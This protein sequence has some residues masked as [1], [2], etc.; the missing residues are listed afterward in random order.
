MIATTIEQSKKLLELGLN[1]ET[2]D[3][4]YNPNFYDETYELTVHPY[5]DWI[6]PKYTEGH[7]F[8]LLPAWSLSALLELMPNLNGRIPVLCRSM[9]NNKW[10]VVYH[11]TAI[12]EAIQTECYDEPL[13][14]AFE[15]I[16]WLLE[17]KS[18]D[19]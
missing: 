11:S 1:P 3:M 4:S 13:D 14:A 8:N 17:Q 18:F 6:P 5:K 15:M 19:Y 12:N 16:V 7:N 10:W 2:A 9:R